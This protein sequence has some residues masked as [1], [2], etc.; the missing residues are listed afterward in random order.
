MEKREVFLIARH[1]FRLLFRNRLFLL[2]FFFAYVV[3]LYLQV[4]GQT[5]FFENTLQQSAGAIPY[6][7]AY[8]FTVLQLLP[9]VVLG[10]DAFCRSRRLDSLD[11]I[12]YR[13]AD[14]GSHVAG[15]ALGFLGAW[16]MVYA[17]FW[18]SAMILLAL[19][20][21]SSFHAGLYL[22]YPL[23]IVVP[24]VIFS[25]GF[26]FLVSQL[27]QSRALGLLLTMV[28][29]GVLL[30]FGGNV[31]NGVLDPL[32]LVLPAG[33]S[34]FTGLAH[35]TD[36]LLQRSGWLFLGIGCIGGSVVLFP[37]LPNHP[38]R[39]VWL[40]L[41]VGCVLL[42]MLTCGIYA[43]RHLERLSNRD[44][45]RTI[46]KRY[47]KVSKATTLTHDIDYRQEGDKME[48][49]SVLTVTNDG[50]DSLPSLL[51]YLNPGLK[52]LEIKERDNQLVFKQEGQV[53]VVKRSLAPGDTLELSVDYGGTI[54]ESICH[55]NIPDEKWNE[56]T[57]TSEMS[58]RHGKRYAYLEEDYTL[59]TPGTLWYPTTLPPENP[60]SVYDLPVDFV[61]YTLRVHN[62]QGLTVI[63]QGRRSG[64]LEDIRFQDEHPLPGITLCMGAYS[65]RRVEVD[66]ITYELNL[67]EGHERILSAYTRATRSNIQNII[68]EIRK[69]TQKELGKE[70][71]FARLM[72]TE[73]P[74]HFASYFQGERGASQYVQPELILGQEW[75][76][77]W[78][79]GD[80]DRD[81][82][83]W[84]YTYFF[85]EKNLT[86]S[87]SWKKHFKRLYIS[88]S[89]KYLISTLR[90]I[91]KIDGHT[92]QTSVN[93]LLARALF[94][95]YTSHIHSSRYPFFNAFAQCIIRDNNTTSTNGRENLGGNFPETVGLPIVAY[96][97][98]H[99][100]REAFRDSSL[101]STLFA[102]MLLLES[103]EFLDRLMVKGIPIDSMVS[104]TTEY[105]A[106]NL[107]RKIDFEDF[108]KDFQRRFGVDMSPILSAQY[109]R[110]ELPS[111]IVEPIGE[112]IAFGIYD[113]RYSTFRIY[114]DSDVDGFIHL[115]KP[116]KIDDG[117]GFSWFKRLY[118]Y[119]YEA[120]EVKA[121]SGIEVRTQ[122]YG[123]AV[124]HTNLSHNVPEMYTIGF[125]GYQN[126]TTQYII[127][128]N[129]EK[130]QLPANEIIV[131]NEDKGFVL[132]QPG[133]SWLE[134]WE[135]KNKQ[136]WEQYYS[137][138]S[139]ISTPRWRKIINK[140]NYGSPVRSCVGKAAGNGSTFAEWHA[141]LPE[142]GT[143]E[144]WVYASR[145]SFRDQG[146]TQ[147]YE[148]KQ[149]K[150]QEN[151]EITNFLTGQWSSLGTYECNA[152]E[153]V[154]T[155]SD[156]GEKGQIIYGDAV[157]WVLIER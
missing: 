133:L 152:G 125:K 36:F 8:L 12:Y 78:L 122:T 137:D 139:G 2:Y 60:V 130:F 21:E 116:I 76:W 64:T 51:L 15:V 110:K 61:R 115:E 71:S 43:N 68:R 153:C 91:G 75:G 41:T 67:L 77:N 25:L 24:G 96:L 53:I 14:N 58:L 151:M 87:F 56:S 19:F 82:N 101:S 20:S 142:T 149:E 1:H 84:G 148:I 126:D 46:Y 140:S 155:L 54:D 22:F 42:G 94:Y 113:L 131:D 104:F 10:N 70:Y 102:H 99:S 6:L 63:S 147:Y 121:H 117:G 45:Y 103:R 118:D 4:T 31:L 65:T 105:L 26:T 132:N 88:F 120:Y 32:G 106:T 90:N 11:A 98:G 23:T 112:E 50:E 3:T 39:R 150:W 93:S 17:L 135:L 97:S 136:P 35:P 55:V 119:E 86:E 13:P 44:A 114:N 28:T 157:K 62:P 81:I 69:R 30:G 52:V 89:T 9:A 107:F 18:L 100:F 138:I 134:R 73:T 143:Y 141:Q 40:P 123:E 80:S 124:I 59:L 111:Y 74:S 109:E 37:R 33:Y 47:A 38:G 144:I 27:A 7:N 156:K 95:D 154:V 79:H 57:L 108:N 128:I 146:K 16:G 72:I 83:I 129:K 145:T 127:S 5:R 29:L 85:Q 92:V 49:K 66:G 34:D 48:A